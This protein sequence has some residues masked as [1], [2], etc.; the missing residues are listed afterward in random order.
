[1]IDGVFL[2]LE[3]FCLIVAAKLFFYLKEACFTRIRKDSYF[4]SGNEIL[5]KT[6][7][8]KPNSE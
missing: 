8:I 6:V 4:F 1:M 7:M 2:P 3:Y 5:R